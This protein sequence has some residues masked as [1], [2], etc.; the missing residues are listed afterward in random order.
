MQGAIS[1]M[2]EPPIPHDE[3]QR[4][5]ALHGLRILDTAPEERFD[6]I[7]RLAARMFDVPVALVSLIDAERQWFKSRVGMNLCETPRGLSFCGH[8]ILQS[9]A[10]VVED[11]FDDER[12]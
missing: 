3:P 11:A 9:E 2:R 1:R 10:M 5:A 4:L 8:A 6:R 7:T 12:F